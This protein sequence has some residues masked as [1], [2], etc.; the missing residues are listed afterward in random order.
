MLNPSVHVHTHTER[1]RGEDG[2]YCFVLQIL[3]SHH[4]VE[5]APNIHDMVPVTIPYSSCTIMVKYKYHL[6]FISDLP[7]NLYDDNCF[8]ET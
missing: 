1:V 4:F 6:L 5:T 2:Q 8:S 3:F 7:T